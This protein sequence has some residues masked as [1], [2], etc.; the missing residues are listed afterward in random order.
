MRIASTFTPVKSHIDNATRQTSVSDNHHPQVQFRSGDSVQLQ[1][2]TVQPKFSGNFVLDWIS[3]NVF[4]DPPPQY[5]LEQNVTEG[6]DLEALKSILLG[7]HADIDRRDPRDELKTPLI[8][9]VE[10]RHDVHALLLVCYSAIPN[11]TIDVDKWGNNALDY[12]DKRKDWTKQQREDFKNEL[13]RVHRMNKE[14]TLDNMEA[15]RRLREYHDALM[16]PY[17][18][19]SPSRPQST[20]SDIGSSETDSEAARSPLPPASGTR[21]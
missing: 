9:A 16:A 2:K 17:E 21:S 1:R 12:V 19:A 13:L 4:N 18:S 10:N 8:K 7:G 15:N 11:G 20:D 6:G 5:R 14:A 3:A